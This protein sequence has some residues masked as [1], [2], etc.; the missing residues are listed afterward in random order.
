MSLVAERDAL[1]H[2]VEEL[3]ARVE[4]MEAIQGRME[5]LAQVITP[6]PP[7]R[8]DDLRDLH[9]LA[10]LRTRGQLSAEEFEG[11]KKA[12]LSKWLT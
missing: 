12:L 3:Q 4:S 10:A 7:S 1:R 9:E 2:Q 5:M 6:E 8:R 11:A